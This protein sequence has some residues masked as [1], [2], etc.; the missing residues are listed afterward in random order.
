MKTLGRYASAWLSIAALCGAAMSAHAASPWPSGPV[1]IVVPYSA[2]GTTDYGAR[3]IAKRLAEQTGGSFIVD[4]KAGGS[5]TIGELFVARSAPNGLTLLSNDT[6]YTMLPALFKHL[7]WD[8]EKDLIPVTTLLQ[9]PVVLVVPANSPFKNLD[10]LRAYAKANPG[11]LNFGSGGT[12]SSTH[13]QGVEFDQDAGV[14]IT[15]V[16]YKGAGDAMLGLISGQVQVLITA[17]PTAISQV[18]GGQAR[19]LAV[20]GKTRLPALPNVPTFSEAGLPAY[21]VHN[22]FG[23]AVPKGTP[24]AIIEEIATQVQKVLAEPDLIK[25]LASQGVEPGGI[26]P[27]QFAAL[28]RHDTAMWTQAAKRAGLQPN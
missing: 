3:L 24:H 22:W 5:G 28:I 27:T 21:D 1:H 14:N 9:T 2:G 7:P 26:S 15:H 16:P 23:L 17:A 18:Q 6:A 4:N 8:L 11:K 20:T 10:E 12:G 13:L 25:L 19:A